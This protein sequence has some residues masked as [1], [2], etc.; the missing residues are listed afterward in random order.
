MVGSLDWKFDYLEVPVLAAVS[1]QNFVIS[2]GPVVGLNFNDEF[3][4]A[5]RTDSPG[6]KAI[7]VGAGLGLS[8][9]VAR[10]RNATDTRG[11][12]SDRGDP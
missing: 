7:D 4:N 11:P 1:F 3:R 9:R 8:Y 6:I 12:P 2:A 10:Q 5:R